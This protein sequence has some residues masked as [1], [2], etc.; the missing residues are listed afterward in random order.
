[1]AELDIQPADRPGETVSNSPL[2]RPSSA[3]TVSTGKSA[4]EAL[5]HLYKMSPTAGVATTDYAAIN[6]VSIVAFLLGLAGVLSLFAPIL[7]IVPAIGLLLGIIAL[8]Q[9]R[10]SNRTQTGSGFAVLGVVLALAFGGFVVGK[11][12][13]SWRHKRAD[14]AQISV[15]VT[16]I[17]DDL[18]AARY[19]KAYALFSERFRGRV[20]SENFVHTMTGFNGIPRLGGMKGFRWNGEDMVFESN[21]DTGDQTVT[22]M[23]FLNFENAPDPQRENMI[24]VREGGNWVIEDIPQMFPSA[25]PRVPGAPRGPRSGP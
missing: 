15:L 5:S 11:D 25:K 17:G 3:E 18:A 21:P 13:I 22:A 24:F 19:D 10:D 8:I 20:S 16:K 6:S 12:F 23:V 4:S 2:G 14:E 9:I 1:M 7:L